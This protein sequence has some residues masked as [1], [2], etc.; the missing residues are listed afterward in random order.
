M[1][2]AAAVIQAHYGGELGG[3]AIV[4]ALMGRISPAGQLF[5]RPGAVSLRLGPV[6]HSLLLYRGIWS[7]D[8]S[9]AADDCRA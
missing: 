1:G 6:V 3:D 8:T 5:Q 4:D 7:R 2:R 9:V